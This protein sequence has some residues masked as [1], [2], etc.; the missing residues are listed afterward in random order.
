MLQ[1][2]MNLILF[3]KILIPVD[4]AGIRFGLNR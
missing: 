4:Y 3:V 1:S 2:D